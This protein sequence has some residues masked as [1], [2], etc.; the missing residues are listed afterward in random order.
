MQLCIH[1]QSCIQTFELLKQLSHTH[2]HTHTHSPLRTC[3]C[4]GRNEISHSAHSL[5]FSLPSW[6]NRS[7][8][9]QD[10]TPASK[11][12][13]VHKVTE[14]DVRF[15]SYNRAEQAQCELP[16][17]S[18]FPRTVCRTVTGGV[19]FDYGFYHGAE[20]DQC[21]F[22]LLGISPAKRLQVY[23]PYRHLK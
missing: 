13:P 11:L 8:A 4:Q 14:D 16:L 20:Q 6:L 7:Q 12:S 3:V 17:L 22:P 9:G 10:F 23:R 19:R 2:T 1:M 18:F 15:C 21:G 5:L